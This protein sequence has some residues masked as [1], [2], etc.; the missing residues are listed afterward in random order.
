MKLYDDFTIKV[1]VNS[2]ALDLKI[3]IFKNLSY[4]KLVKNCNKLK[5]FNYSIDGNFLFSFFEN[6]NK[7]IN[8]IFYISQ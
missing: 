8:F 3:E 1:I 7:I 2:V 6:D 4:K 5:A